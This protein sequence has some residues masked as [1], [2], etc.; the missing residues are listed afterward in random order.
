MA[1]LG[2]KASRNSDEGSLDNTKAM[3]AIRPLL[4]ALILFFICLETKSAQTVT[5]LPTPNEGKRPRVVT[6]KEGTVHLIYNNR[7]NIFYSKKSPD[8]IDFSEPIQVNS[9]D[10]SGA[11]ADVAIGKNGTVH[12]LFHGNIF[13]IREQIKSENR[14][15]KSSDIKYTFYTR[16]QP[17][18]SAFDEQR[19]LSKNVWGFD[20]GCTLAADQAGNVYTFFAGTTRKGN[21]TVRQ[22][23]LSKSGDNG[24]TFGNPTPIDL[25]K[26]V[27]ACCHLKADVDAKGSLHIVYRVAEET[28]DRDSFVLTSKDQGKTFSPTALDQWKLRACP[29]SAYSFAHSGDETFV[30]W[31]NE[32]EIYLTSLSKKI[33]ITPP[34]KDLKR[35][36]AILGHNHRGEVLITWA[37]GDNFNKPHHLKWQLYD[38]EGTAIGPVGTKENAFQ[39]W[40]NS[41]V[42]A[43]AQGNFTILH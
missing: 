13:Y 33:H 7:G 16:L 40:G 37:E 31:R 39:R 21:E 12:L 24:S 10:R 29:G 28:V 38:A 1:R 42:F 4:I 36:A 18:A 19:D 35:R 25:G 43:D 34:G 23:F 6:D 9:V 32:S 17:G 8:S 27:C 14:K 15:L 5:P 30:S 41:A 2:S 26:G 11:V 3:N 22:V 20:G